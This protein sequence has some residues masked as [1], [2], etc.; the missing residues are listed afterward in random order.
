[1]IC[2]PAILLFWKCA[3]CSRTAVARFRFHWKTTNGFWTNKIR[4]HIILYHDLCDWVLQSGI[5]AVWGNFWNIFEDKAFFTGVARIFHWVM[6][7][8]ITCVEQSG[9]SSVCHLNIVGFLLKKGLTR[10]EEHPRILTPL[11]MCMLQQCNH[12]KILTEWQ[13]RGDTCK[14][15]HSEECLITCLRWTSHI[16]ND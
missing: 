5:L 2:E 12:A 8:G 3:Y 14:L 13:S 11:A 10:G 7:G 1:M 4:H 9:L 16:L 6:G 15:K